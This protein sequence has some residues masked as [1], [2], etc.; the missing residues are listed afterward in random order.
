M[1][2]TKHKGQVAIE[3]LMYAGLFMIIAIGA[4]VL[5]SFTERG[6]ISLRES[7]LVT[8]FGYKFATAPTIAYKG[9]E[10]F[11]YDTSFAKS[12]DGRPYN[13]TY[14]CMHDGSCSV[15]LKWDGTYNTHSYSYVIAPAYYVI[16]DPADGEISC[17][18]TVPFGDIDN[19]D[20]RDAVYLHP[21]ASPQGHIIFRN[22]GIQSGDVYPTIEMYC[23]VN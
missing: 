2:G 14:I 15:L 17:V 8:A 5:T 4:Y 18:E 1:D 20:I 21:Q 16:G 23:E 3:F 22:I 7:Q 9:G 11:T 10:G 13:I 19:P 12:L 6:E